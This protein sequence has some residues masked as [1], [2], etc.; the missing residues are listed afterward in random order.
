VAVTAAADQIV[1]SGARLNG[2]L[3]NKQLTSTWWFEYGPTAAYGSTTPVQQTGASVSVQNVNRTVTLQSGSSWHARLVV[4]TAGGTRFG[5]DI[6]FSTPLSAWDLWA[7][8]VFGSHTG[9]AAFN[10]DFDGDGVLNGVEYSLGSSAVLATERPAVVAERYTSEQSGI[11]YL[12]IVYRPD[13]GVSGATLQPEA[14]DDLASWQSGSVIVTDLPDG[15]KRA[16]ATGFERFMR[17]KATQN[18]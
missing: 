5:D 14:S 12:S 4:S 9:N 11:T 13:T 10:G 6:G 18:P 16:V 2:T 1:S 3:D 17:L 15:R 8:G 7:D